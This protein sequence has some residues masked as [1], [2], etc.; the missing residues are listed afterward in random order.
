MST[1]PARERYTAAELETAETALPVGGVEVGPRIVREESP[2]PERER[3][4]D[5]SAVAV[6]WE[7]GS[8]QCTKAKSKCQLG[9]Y[10]I[11]DAM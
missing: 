3:M 6:A 8:V 9:D 5:C 11:K 2:R 7:V 10:Y 4:E 1:R